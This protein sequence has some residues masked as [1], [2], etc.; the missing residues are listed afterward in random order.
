[1]VLRDSFI[2]TAS[3][4]KIIMIA[5]VSPSSKSADHTMNTLRY[6]SRLKTSFV[7]GVSA[8]ANRKALP[9][10]YKP[11]PKIPAK[12]DFEAD[13]RFKRKVP[14]S[15]HDSNP[16]SWATW[17]TSRGNSLA[18]AGANVIQGSLHNLH[19][20]WPTSSH[21]S[22]QKNPASHRE[23]LRQPDSWAMEIDDVDYLRK[24]MKGEPMLG[25]AINADQ[26]MEV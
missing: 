24:T 4:V 7:Q 5:C 20:G 18:E 21:R 26:V 10:V 11:P 9:P 19:S 1:M 12:D 2:S 13:R 22:P 6:G 23:D 14:A 25:L 3:A 15:I 8:N 16:S 17:V